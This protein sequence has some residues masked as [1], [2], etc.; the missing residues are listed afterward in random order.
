MERAA[1]LSAVSSR[2]H[3]WWVFVLLGVPLGIAVTRLTGTQQ[4]IAFAAVGAGLALLLMHGKTGGWRPQSTVSTIEWFATLSSPQER[5]ERRRQQRI[6]A[7]TV[8][9]LLVVLNLSALADPTPVQRVLGSAIILFAAFPSWRLVAGKDRGIAFLPFFGGIYAVYYALPVFLMS[10]Y[11]LPTARGRVNLEAFVEP[12]LVLAF[13][14]LCLLLLGYYGPHHR[15]LARVVP[16]VNMQWKDLTSLRL[17]G[18][19]V[20]IIG[21][22]GYYTLVFIPVPAAIRQA[23]LFLADM[24]LLSIALL[25]ILQLKGRLGPLGGFF[26]WGLLLPARLLI[27]VGVGIAAPALIVGLVLLMGHATLRRRLPWRTIAAGLVAAFFLLAVKGP[28]RAVTWARGTIGEQPLVERLQVYGEIA[29]NLATG[30]ALWYARAG[31]LIMQ[32]VGHLLVLAEM[33]RQVPD[34]VP[35]WGG[36][37][38]YP[39]LVKPIPRLIYPGKPQEVMGGT[40][41]RRYEL[42]ASTDFTTSYNLPQ[43]VELYIDFGTIGVL[44]G[45]FLL[46]VLYRLIQHVLVHSRMGIGGMVAGLYIFAGL[47]VIENNLSM[48]LGGLVWQ[49]VFVGGVHFLV[50]MMESRQAPAG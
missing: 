14:G 50:K 38:L 6:L 4:F 2:R 28:F 31:E 39:L 5:S 23:T 11:Q 20:G 24:S 7:L 30:E 12:A 10:E 29:L 41:G 8:A 40:F 43:L 36:E 47:L 37:S 48:V 35:F 42:L 33:V 34:E 22:I 49:P 18:G 3:L 26:L 21:T 17:L 15:L 44:V 16:K 1:F 32:R 25:F 13:V 19:L 27:T 45:M 9:V 46:G